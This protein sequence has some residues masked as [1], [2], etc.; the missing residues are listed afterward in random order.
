MAIGAR[1]ALFD[2]VSREKGHGPSPDRLGI[3]FGK[4]TNALA[5]SRR[6]LNAVQQRRVKD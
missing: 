1:L 5:Q 6:L 2:F 4:G 3:R